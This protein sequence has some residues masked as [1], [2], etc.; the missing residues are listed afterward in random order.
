M[1]IDEPGVVMAGG[2]HVALFLDLKIMKCQTVES[3]HYETINIPPNPD[4]KVFNQNLDNVL[5]TQPTTLNSIDTQCKWLQN[6]LI[7]A[8]KK[9]F[10]VRDNKS[11]PK[12]INKV[13]KTI[14]KLR[15]KGRSSQD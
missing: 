12:Q 15:H 10:G 11:K 4:Y 13:P 6:A 2:D 3:P 1:I 9:T 5:Q 8:G 7:T 14:R